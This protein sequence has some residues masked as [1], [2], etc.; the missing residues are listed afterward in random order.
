V[1]KHLKKKTIQK[2]S[3]MVL[4][5]LKGIKDINKADEKVE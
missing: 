1:H 2:R 3:K 4:D 5:I